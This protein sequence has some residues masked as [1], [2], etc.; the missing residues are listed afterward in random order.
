MMFLHIQVF[1][2][3]DYSFLMDKLEKGLYTMIIFKTH[4]KWKYSK[5]I[6]SENSFL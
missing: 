5:R 2:I 1:I 4:S 3:C 6:L